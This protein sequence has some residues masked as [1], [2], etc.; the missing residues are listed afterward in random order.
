[1]AQLERHNWMVDRR[2]AWE[3]VGVTAAANNNH[4][5]QHMGRRMHRTST[6]RRMMRPAPAEEGW[7]TA[8]ARIPCSRAQEGEGEEHW[9]NNNS[10]EGQHG[11]L[12]S[13][14][15]ASHGGRALSGSCRWDGQKDAEVQA[16]VSSW[17]TRPSP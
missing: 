13:A 5:T 15:K 14:A 2:T 12:A 17:L 3:V 9:S 4:S 6:V 8:R 1:M 7:Y 10:T 11:N 16:S